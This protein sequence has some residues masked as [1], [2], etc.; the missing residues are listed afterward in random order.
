[1][2]PVFQFRGRWKEEL[3]CTGSGGAFVLENPIGVHAVYLPTK[4]VWQRTAP[5]WAK[6]LWPVLRIELEAWCKEHTAQLFVDATA[7][8]TIE[9]PIHR[10]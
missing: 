9:P 2:L 7:T 5:A 6:D 1:M 4:D 3:I 10:L 8:V